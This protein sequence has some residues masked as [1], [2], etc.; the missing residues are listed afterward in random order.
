MDDVYGPAIDALKKRLEEYER[1]A[2]ETRGAINML[3]ETAGRPPAYSEQEVSGINGA[4]LPSQI[5]ADTFYGKKLQTAAREYLDMRKARGEGPAKPREIYD[6]LRAGGFKFEA[7]DDDIALVG[8]RALL[9][10]RSLTFHKM[11][12]GTYGLTAWYPNVKNKKATDKTTADPQ[13]EESA[14]D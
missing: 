8:L 4:S 5:V 6:A 12:N 14:D 9:R 3:C 13:E 1:K 7:K 11:E 2:R 10:K